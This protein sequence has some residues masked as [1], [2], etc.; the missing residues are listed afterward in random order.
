METRDADLLWDARE[1]LTLTIGRMP[2]P[3]VLALLRKADPS[4]DASRQYG[5][6]AENKDGF[7]VELLTVDTGNLEVTGLPD[8]LTVNPMVG[9]DALLAL[10]RLEAIVIDQRGMPV[11]VVAPEVRTFTLLKE[12]VSRQSSR[13][14]EKRRRDR[15]QAAVLREIVVKELGLG[16][17]AE[18][19]RQVP[20]YLTAL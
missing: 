5:L 7:I 8:D 20:A 6:S 12:W 18:L 17:D 3:A 10:P 19:M 4:F 9:M 15:D 14:P 11:R 13:P 2:P 1:R 16:F